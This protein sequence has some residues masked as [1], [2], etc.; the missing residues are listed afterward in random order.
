MQVIMLKM[1][2]IILKIH[3]IMLQIQVV[4]FK[5]KNKIIPNII[6]IIKLDKFTVQI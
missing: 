5:E 2:V 1:Q 6:K 4:I 3:I